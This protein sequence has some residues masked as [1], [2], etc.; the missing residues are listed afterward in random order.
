MDSPVEIS[1]AES[2]GLLNDWDDSKF[3]VLPIQE[4]N[5]AIGS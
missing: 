3:N 4:T 2:R 1:L 5:S